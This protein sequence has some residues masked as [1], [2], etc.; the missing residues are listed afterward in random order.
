MGHR[1]QKGSLT[2]L[3]NIL[4]TLLS[5]LVALATLVRM[6]WDVMVWLASTWRL[7]IFSHAYWTFSCLLWKDTFLDQLSCSKTRS[8]CTPLD[9][10]FHCVAQIGNSLVSWVSEFQVEAPMPDSLPIL[11]FLCPRLCVL[12]F[13]KEVQLLM[14]AGILTDLVHLLSCGPHTSNL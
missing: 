1:R 9:E 12:S 8:F 4:Y 14:P 11:F 6:K 13:K 10:P 7:T 2:L 3:G 5:V